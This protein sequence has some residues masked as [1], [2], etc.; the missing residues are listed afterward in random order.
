MKLKGVDIICLN[1]ITHD[2]ECIQL[3]TMEGTLTGSQSGRSIKE[4][5]SYETA[6]FCTALK[7]NTSWTFPRDEKISRCSGDQ[8]WPRIGIKYEDI[9]S[10][11]IDTIKDLEDYWRSLL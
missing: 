11:A 6:F 1:A 5:S 7:T 4:L 10:I 3:K 8:F 9:L 2:L